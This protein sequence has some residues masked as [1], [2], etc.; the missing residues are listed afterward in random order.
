MTPEEQEEKEKEEKEEE[1]E[2]KEKDVKEEK[3]TKEKK[4]EKV[5]KPIK[6]SSD[7]KPTNVATI[8]KSDNEKKSSADNGSSNAIPMAQDGGEQLIE[9]AEKELDDEFSKKK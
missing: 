1:K 4:V 2:T 5:E 6:N 7:I 8:P 3:E 9:E